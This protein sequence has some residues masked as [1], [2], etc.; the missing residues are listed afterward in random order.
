M[1]EDKRKSR[2]LPYQA[3]IARKRDLRAKP[4]GRC[5]NGALVRWIMNSK[6][7]LKSAHSFQN[8]ETAQIRTGRL[9][10]QSAQLAQAR[11]SRFSCLPVTGRL[12]QRAMDEILAQHD[13]TG[14][15][16]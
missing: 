10:R 6:M 3:L 7:R 11:L 14:L 16:A 12:R 13:D 15:V 1:W 8:A 9:V 2:F 5:R 4:F